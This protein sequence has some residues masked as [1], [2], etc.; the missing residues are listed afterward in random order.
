VSV[1]EKNKKNIIKVIKYNAGLTSKKSFLSFQVTSRKNLLQVFS[2]S[3]EQQKSSSSFLQAT[4]CKIFKSSSHE[5]RKSSS[6][7][8]SHKNLL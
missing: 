8:S 2:S 6:F 3:Y 4:S 7:F 5:P 1:K